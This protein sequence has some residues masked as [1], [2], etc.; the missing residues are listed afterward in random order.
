MVARTLCPE[1]PASQVSVGY[2]LSKIDGMLPEGVGKR[3]AF[4][5]T[6]PASPLTNELLENAKLAV[7]KLWKQRSYDPKKPEAIKAKLGYACDQYEASAYLVTGALHKP[8]IS[9]EEAKY[10]G[11]R[12]TNIIGKSGSVGKQLVPL[13][14]RGAASA[15]QIRALLL[16][17]AALNF[18]PPPRAAPAPAPAPAPH[19]RCRQHQHHRRQCSRRRCRRRLCRCLW[20]ASVWCTS[21]RSRS[22]S[23]VTSCMVTMLRRGIAPFQRMDSGSK[24]RTAAAG[25]RAPRRACRLTTGPRAS[26]ARLQRPTRRRR[27]RVSKCSCSRRTTTRSR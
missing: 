24:A 20:S 3:R 23:A 18:E 26:S 6:G 8:L 15:P 9:H 22:V 17:P 2:L 5:K 10:I 27:L 4:V 19:S 11:K 12:I 21:I 25:T 14:K 16:Q 13:K 7:E 1:S